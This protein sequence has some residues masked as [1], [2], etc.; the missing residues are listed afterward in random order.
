MSVTGDFYGRVFSRKIRYQE[1]IKLF[2]RRSGNRKFKI[3][4]SVNQP[5]KSKGIF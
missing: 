3:V 1:N 5:I 2:L 4:K